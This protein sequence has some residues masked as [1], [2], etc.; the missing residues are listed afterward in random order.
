LEYRKPQVIPRKLDPAKQQAFI[1]AY[2]NLLN[3]LGDDE[4]VLFADAVHPT[5]AVRPAGCWA[6]KDAK[7]AIEQT[8]GR[9]RLNIHGA[10][11]L[12]TGATR[13]IEATTVDALSTIALLMAI[14]LMYPTNRLLR[15]LIDTDSEHHLVLI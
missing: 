15:V 4:A 12:E 8:S 10:I 1:E 14:M 9:Q 2:D 5:H 6:P 3:T 7:V 11:D 13:M